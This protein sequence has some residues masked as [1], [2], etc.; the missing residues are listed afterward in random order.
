MLLF[1]WK[2]KFFFF[3]FFTSSS[4]IR[5][6]CLTLKG[7]ESKLPLSFYGCGFH[8]RVV[9]ER[10]MIKN[11]SLQQT[12]CLMIQEHLT[13]GRGSHW[14]AV[15]LTITPWGRIRWCRIEESEFSSS[16]QLQW[17]HTTS[18][19]SISGSHVGRQWEHLLHK[20]PR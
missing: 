9:S 3:F 7:R 5:Q 4:K 6:L 20:Q 15:L 13:W 14:R 16:I 10:V 2:A 8:S 12:L 17:I 1:C 11:H 18:T 19:S